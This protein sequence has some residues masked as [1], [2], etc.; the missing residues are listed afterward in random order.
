MTALRRPN[1]SLMT[2]TDR[3]PSGRV[4][5]GTTKAALAMRRGD[6]VRGTG[7]MAPPGQWA[8]GGPAHPLPPPPPP[9]S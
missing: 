5:N 6:G 8:V 3:P 7:P 1:R 2:P 4:K 9:P